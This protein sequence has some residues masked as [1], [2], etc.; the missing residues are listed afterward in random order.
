MAPPDRAVVVIASYL[1]LCQGVGKNKLAD[2]LLEL[3]SAEREYVQLHRD[4]TVSSL[5]LAPTVE[6]GKVVWR[7]SALVR[8]ARSGY[9]RAGALE[10]IGAPSVCRCASCAHTP[11]VRAVLLWARGQPRTDGRRG[12]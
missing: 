10:P 11:A 1:S 2:K 3:L 9:A 7:D 8:A 4:T 12:R 6:D 5:T